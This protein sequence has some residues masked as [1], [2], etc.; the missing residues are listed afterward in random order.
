VSPRPAIFFTVLFLILTPFYYLVDRP[1]P[2][3]NDLEEK[4]ESLLKL[5]GIDGITVTRG[6]ETIHYQKTPDGKLYQLLVPAKAFIPQDLMQATA[7]LLL[8]AKSV[9]VVAEN[10][11]DLKQF[12]LDQP[13]AVMLVQA[14]GQDKPI[15]I[16]FGAENPTK[17]A[18]YAQIEGVP[19]VFLL[20]RSLEYYQDLM[21]QWVEGKQGKNA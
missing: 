18:I 11:N 6:T 12:G 20:G 19:K 5:S 14:P 17:T 9:E 4:Q 21:F 7:E 16:T 3:Q 2:I 13:S 1:V 15:K 8:G 10:N